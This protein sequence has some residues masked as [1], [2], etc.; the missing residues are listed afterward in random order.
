MG[1]ARVIAARHLLQ[2]TDDFGNLDIV[3]LRYLY[4]RNGRNRIAT[5]TVGRFDFPGPAFRS[6]V[7]DGRRETS[8]NDPA[9]VEREIAPRLAAIEPPLDDVIVEC[10][11]EQVLVYRWRHRVQPDQFPGFKELVESVATA[12]RQAR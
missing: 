3:D 4:N 11:G 10:D 1:P 6:V 9:E 5:S 7:D 12:L 2:F 8:G